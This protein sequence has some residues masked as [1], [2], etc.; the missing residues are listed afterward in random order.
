M[1]LNKNKLEE[2]KKIS[3][4]HEFFES[5]LQMSAEL[6]LKLDADFEAKNLEGL[7]FHA[8][9]LKS[10]SYALG[11]EDLGD[12]CKTFELCMD[13]EYLKGKKDDLSKLYEKTINEILNYKE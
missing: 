11:L 7:H 9:S 3:E 13:W 10:S 8:H 1:I 5:Y 4:V 6:K 2:L 12:L